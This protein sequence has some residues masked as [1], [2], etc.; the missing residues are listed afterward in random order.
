MDHGNDLEDGMP[1]HID[2]ADDILDDGDEVDAN[3]MV[4]PQGRLKL[5]S[6]LSKRQ[7]YRIVNKVLD[8]L[9]RSLPNY[10]EVN[11]IFYF[12]MHQKFCSAGE[13]ETSQ[14]CKIFLRTQQTK[15]LHLCLG[16]SDQ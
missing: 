5:Y 13:G 14:E 10:S 12:K 11:E 4:K 8:L 7:R 2:G 6:D 9:G 1:G 3:R 15:M 16:S